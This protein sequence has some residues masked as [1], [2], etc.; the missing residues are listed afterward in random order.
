MPTLTSRRARESATEQR[1][2]Y[3]ALDRLVRAYQF[4]DRQRVCYRGLSITEC[5]ALQAIV[6]EP[7]LTQRA[8]AHALRLDKST[9]SRVVD[10][11]ESRGL[12]ERSPDPGDGRAYRL[13]P[14]ARGRRLHAD[15]E[16]DILKRQADLLRDVPATVRRAATE[17]L[18]RLAEDAMARFGAD[19]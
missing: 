2:L 9:T 17:V 3:E 12:A 1:A 7:A 11:L 4:R 16:A 6:H 14:T 10:A 13:A 18:S 19:G 15:I 5:Y 8:L